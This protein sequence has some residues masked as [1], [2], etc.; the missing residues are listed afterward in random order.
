MFYRDFMAAI[1]RETISEGYGQQLLGLKNKLLFNI[2]FMEL[3]SKI[4]IRLIAFTRIIAI[5]SP[6]QV[7]TNGDF[8]K[9]L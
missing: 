8:V 9:M 6:I 2:N 3:T 1:L 7:I 5:D 4:L